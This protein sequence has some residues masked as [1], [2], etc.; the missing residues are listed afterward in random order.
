MLCLIIV[1][2][3]ILYCLRAPHQLTCQLG[4]GATRL[5]NHFLAVSLPR[6]I[7]R[8]THGLRHVAPRPTQQH[9]GLLMLL[10]LRLLLLLLRLL[11]LRL[12]MAFTTGL[13]WESSSWCSERL[14]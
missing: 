11:L 6:I 1:A 2:L 13:A 4:D 8:R 12:Y 14:L 7:N 5:G 10:P 3:P 9:L